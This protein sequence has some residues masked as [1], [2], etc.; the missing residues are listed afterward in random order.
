VTALRDKSSRETVAQRP[1]DLAPA[2]MDAVA[3]IFHGFRARMV[4]IRHGA[5]APGTPPPPVRPGESRAGSRS[6]A[7]GGAAPE[8]FAIE[9]SQAQPY[10]P[11]AR[12]RAVDLGVALLVAPITVT[13]GVLVVRLLG[14]LQIVSTGRPAL[15]GP[16]SLVV[17]SLLLLSSLAAQAVSEAVAGVSPGKAALGLRV[18]EWDSRV[19]SYARTLVRNLACL[20]D[21]LFLGAPARDQMERSP[22]RQRLGDQWA[23]T[24]VV[25][26]W[27]V[28]SLVRVRL[29][30]VWVAIALGGAVRAGLDVAIVVAVAL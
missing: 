30:P 5:F 16:R 29:P 26:A 12:A 28:P 27:A 19:P 18:V 9:R 4:R 15:L 11:R 10:L 13:V 3:L 8:V 17:A 25:P 21:G 6:E 7:S 23:G 20:L 1:P 2:L 14:A 24:I 22:W